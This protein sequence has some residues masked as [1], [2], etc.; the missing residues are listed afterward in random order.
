M[1]EL[2][3]LQGE[4]WDMYKDVHGIRPRFWT[5]DKWSDAVYLEDQRQ[6]LLKIMECSG[7]SQD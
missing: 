3:K 2:Q 5:D 1:N 7:R 4:V 6:L